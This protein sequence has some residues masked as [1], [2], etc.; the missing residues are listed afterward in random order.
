V[1][2]IT[3]KILP[4][5]PEP[6]QQGAANNYFVSASAPY[7]RHTV[8]AKVN[9]NASSKLTMQARVGLLDWN[10]YYEPVFGTQL[11]GVAISGQ[12]SG[13]AN[14]TSQN[15][16][17]AA[18]Y[19]VSPN[20]I[21]D[22]YFG[23]NRSYQNV[24]PVD[25]DK[26]IGTDFLG[27]PGTNGNRSFEGGWPLITL[28]GYNGIGVDQPY[29]PWIRHDPGYNYV[30]NASWNKSSHDLRFGF[31]FGRRDL[32]HAQ[33]E[34]E[35]QIGGA[36]GG[37]V[38]NQGVTQIPGGP[39]A[40]RDNTFAAFL[41]GLPQQ[42]GRTLQVPDQIQLRSNFFA[43]YAQDR[44]TISPRLTLSYGVRWEYLPLPHRP[45][46]GIEFYDPTNNTQTICGYQS[47]PQDCGVSTSKLGF[48]PRIGMTFRATNSFVI[49]AAFAISRDPYDIGPRGVR[50]NYPLM[51]AANYQGANTYQPVENWSLGIPA[52]TPPDFG[53]G[54]LNVPS[55]IVV[56]AI[57]KDI[58][59]GYIESWNFTLQK[60]FGQSWIVQASYVGTL[61]IRQ[62]SEI[63]L[64]A[65][66]VLG[67][68]I[69]GEP[70]NKAFGRTATTPEYAPLGTTNY[71]ALQ[72]TVTRRFA[73]GLQVGASYTWSKVIGNTNS[74]VESFPT[75]QD[76][77]YF[78]L[79][80]AVLSYDRTQVLN[81]TGVW[82]LPFGKNKRWANTGLRSKVLGGWQI[83][84]ILTGMTGLPFTVTAS[85][86]SLNL[87]GSTQF[88]DQINP[89]VNII[90]G[91]GPNSTWFD[92]TAFA[93]VTQVRF[94][95]SG[96]NTLRGPALANLDFGIFRGF[97][98]TERIQVQFR[99]EAYNFTNTPHWGLPASNISAVT[100]NQDGT[101][102]NL[103]GFGSITGTDG[104]YLG[105]S[106][107]DERTFRFGLHLSF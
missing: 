71:N 95:N 73:Q 79:N 61:V 60:Q 86:T 31:E 102:R 35:G 99:G 75:V 24:L 58:R 10:S 44:W 37:F 101:I 32:N 6:N 3:A 20:F 23:F 84:G 41:L 28:S 81:A 56:H 76:L 68:G 49:R 38:F 83:N 45:D 106:G 50:T 104:S 18:T 63:D 100:Y 47:I 13:P 96:K 103:G 72:S 46:R 80:R 51:I 78:N 17:A 97:H 33:P 82:E 93:P 92:P 67:A 53:S 15:L 54:I 64:N 21:L 30:T 42:M 39:A 19:I 9:Y 94:G 11:G 55:T 70:L 40:N 65:G 105:R 89:Q 16:T 52:I 91:T 90:G 27:I 43:A 74:S 59:R 22:G 4:L 87:P 5:W 62:F 88:A 2:P 107:M 66:Q 85:G 57:P 48:S 8:D 34:I 1:S 25:L 14:G 7:N 98:V 69:A 36:S 77:S 12:Q 29:M 26:K